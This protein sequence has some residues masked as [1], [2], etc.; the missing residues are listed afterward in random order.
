[1]LVEPTHS[2]PHTPP[3]H[4]RAEKFGT[5]YRDPAELPKFTQQARLQRM[6]RE[7]F[8]TGIDLF[9]EVCVFV[10]NLVLLLGT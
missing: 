7:G 5:D 4:T 8:A 1:V 6:R 10:F 3:Q 9:S 2:H